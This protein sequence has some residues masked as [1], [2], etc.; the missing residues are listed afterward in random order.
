MCIEPIDPLRPPKK[1]DK[2]F[3]KLLDECD[4]M[5]PEDKKKKRADLIR[6]LKMEREP[7]EDLMGTKPR[8]YIVQLPKKYFENGGDEEQRT[9]SKTPLE[10]QPDV[11]KKVRDEAARGN[12]ALQILL[13][14]SC[15]QKTLMSNIFF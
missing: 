13:K 7:G 9:L 12:N 8:P 1:G 15:L 2:R 3:Q 10:T 4:L 11:G 5:Y 14:L 6:R